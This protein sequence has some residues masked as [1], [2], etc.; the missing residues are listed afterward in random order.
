M[1]PKTYDEWRHCITV[2]CDIA[3][4]P[5]YLAKRSSI[6]ANK[7]NKETVTFRERYGEAHLSNVRQWFE[8]ARTE[9]Y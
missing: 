9:L 7:T 5:E 4:T 1:I 3:L 6:L 8:Q 2:E